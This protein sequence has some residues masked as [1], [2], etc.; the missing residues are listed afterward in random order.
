MFDIIQNGRSSLL[1]IIGFLYYK[2]SVRNNTTYWRCNWQYECSARR[3]VAACYPPTVW[4]QYNA[5]CDRLCW[6][7]NASEGYHNR[8][9]KLIRRH[10]PSLY[11]FLEE[12]KKEQ[13]ILKVICVRFLM[14]WKYGDLS[15]ARIDWRKSAFS[16]LYLSMKPTLKTMTF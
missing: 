12:L 11:T 8:L 13:A 2:H 16:I 15:P 7:N 6:T 9:Q 14:A 4:N 5:V 10:H 1:H 3:A